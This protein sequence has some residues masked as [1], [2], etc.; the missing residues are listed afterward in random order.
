[1]SNNRQCINCG[2]ILVRKHGV[3]FCNHCNTGELAYASIFRDE[4]EDSDNVYIKCPG[5]T[6]YEEGTDQVVGGVKFI[7]DDGET[8]AYEVIGKPVFAPNHTK[9][10]RINKDAIGKIR[11][12]QACQDYTVRMRR[13]EG[14]DFFIP[15]YRHPRRKKLRTVEAVSYEP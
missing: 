8:T 6:L 10:R 9:R 7:E 4:V 1:M 2:D 15:S 3:W 12:C 14:A 11:R 13:K 5:A